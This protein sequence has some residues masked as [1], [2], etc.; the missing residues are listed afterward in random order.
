M[1]DSMTDSMTGGEKFT[2]D[3]HVL[4]IG[5]D[6]YARRPLHGAVN[7]IDEVQRLLLGPKV[8]LPASCIQRLASP[9]PGALHETD[10][11]ELPATLANIRNALRGIAARVGSDDRVVIHY[12]GHGARFALPGGSRT[13]H[14]EALAAVDCDQGNWLFDHE[15]NELLR[16]IA[17]R[18][19][20]IVFI[21]DACH[22]ASV[23]RSAQLVSPAGGPPPGLL[24]RGYEPGDIVAVPE[25]PA[26]LAGDISTRS[27]F[28]VE[29]CH[30]VA[31]C[32]DHE[33]ACESVGAD[34]R[35]QGVLTRALVETLGQLEGIDPRIAPW[36][37]LWGVLGDRVERANRMQHVWSSGGLA[38]TVLAG[39]RWTVT[40]A[41]RS[42][43]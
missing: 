34:G 32:L 42:G 9:H 6:A 24:A 1:T 13:F 36:T 27:G 38:R 40:P 20:S 10:V 41:S 26:R 5:I 4:L 25:L 2:G 23:T 29:A 35:P 19:P 43:P 15:L 3:Y 11:P 17:D 7:D 28:G 8:G 12:S 22:S 14:Y 16:A 18:T 30:V 39:P 33:E 37:R 31:A 21:L